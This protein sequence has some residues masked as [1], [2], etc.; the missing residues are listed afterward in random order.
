MDFHDFHDWIFSCLIAVVG[1]YVRYT[2]SSFNILHK[3]VRKVERDVTEL[4][5]KVAGIEAQKGTLDRL[6]D[7]VEDLSKLTYKIAGHLGIGD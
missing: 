5:T 7:S 4:T 3:D 6:Y 1:G 2:H